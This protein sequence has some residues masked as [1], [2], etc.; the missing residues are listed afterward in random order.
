MTN[1][2][3]HIVYLALGSNLGN[4]FENLKEAIAALSPQMTVKAKSHVYETPPWGYEDQP[5]FLNQTLKVQT[6]LQP[7]PLLKHIKRLET[8]LGRQISF[9]NGPRLIDI[10]VLFYDDLVLNTPTLTIP[11]P[12]LHERGFVLLP[13]MDI[14]PDLVHPVTQKT[15]RDML[16]S[17]NLGGIRQV[18]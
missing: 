7:E 17:C 16:A 11:H 15:V 3:Q 5:P 18:A 4:R 14:A 10:D 8:I 13:L 6:Y 12:R 1:F 2:D 9:R